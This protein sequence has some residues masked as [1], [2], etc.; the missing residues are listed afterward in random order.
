[1]NQKWIGRGTL[2]FSIVLHGYM[3]HAAPQ[4]DVE[5]EEKSEPNFLEL[6]ELAPEPEP[7]I[8]PEP[9]EVAEPELEPEPEPVVE[10]QVVEEVLEAEPEP[11]EPQSESEPEPQP[12]PPE[13]TGNTLV[14][15][16]DGESDF[17]AEQGSGRARRGAVRAGV[18]QPSQTRSVVKPKRRPAPVKA[19]PPP[20]EAIPLAQLSKRPVPPPNL[21]GALKRNYPLDARRQ[22]RAGE[23]KVQAR[24]E[25]SGSI[26][27]A[28][29]ASESENGFGAACRKTLLSSKWTA[30]LDRH[31]KP[32]A[33]WVSYR[34][35]FRID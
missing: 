22:G 25:P 1:M 18:S 4:V 14:A 5:T 16:G 29:I 23:A 17:S 8:E 26:G 9:E 19:P 24:V 32:V 13:L 27:F 6:A 10:P 33:T 15:E 21:G 31:G 12:E 3:I 34:C 30:P 7:P 2:V 20:P 28:K 11:A 35:K